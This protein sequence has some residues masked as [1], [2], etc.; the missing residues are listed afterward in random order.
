MIKGATKAWHGQS[1]KKTKKR[2]LCDLRRWDFERRSGDSRVLFFFL[3]LH[4]QKDAKLFCYTS[5][6][7]L[8]APCCPMTSQ[9]NE[10]RPPTI[11]TKWQRGISTYGLYKGHGKAH[12]RRTIRSS[13]VT[14]IHAVL[15]DLLSRT[16]IGSFSRSMRRCFQLRVRFLP[17]RSCFLSAMVRC[18]HSLMRSSQV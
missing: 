17:L 15:L 13:V 11:V 18:Y 9:Y 16:G 3:L 7:R 6:L 1:T 10:Y 14:H 2:I 5:R 8:V 12:N 4:C